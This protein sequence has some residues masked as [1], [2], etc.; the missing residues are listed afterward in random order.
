MASK[1]KQP[2]LIRCVDFNVSDFRDDDF[3]INIYGIDE[4][5]KTY[6]VKINNFKPFIYIK[7]GSKWGENDV[8]EF[9]EHLKDMGD[10]SLKKTLDEYVEEYK[11]VKHKLYDLMQ[12]NIINLFYFCRI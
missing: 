10:Y 1:S 12:I 4:K 9:M 7:V 3:K 2:K 8:E 11:L 5:R 6:N